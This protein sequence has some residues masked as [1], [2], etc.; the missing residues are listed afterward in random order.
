MKPHDLDYYAKIVWN[1]HQMHMHPTKADAIF[2][3]GSIDT[4]VADYAAELFLRGLGDYVVFS[5]GVAHT[6]DRLKVRW[7]GSEAEH[8]A[9]IAAKKGVPKDKI[10]TDTKAQ[11]TGENITLTYELLLQW[12]LHPSSLLL[13]QKPYMERRTYATFKKQW[14]SPETSM[15]VTSSPISYENYFNENNPKELV[16]NIMVGDLQRLKEYPK[17]GYQIEQVIP[18]EVWNAGQQLVGLGYDKHL[19]K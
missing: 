8:F 6:E 16:L 1:Y 18:E 15:L 13:I 3:L 9:H 17:L 2:V 11:N 4:R 5:G 10:L 7:Q 14:P 12:R 19:L